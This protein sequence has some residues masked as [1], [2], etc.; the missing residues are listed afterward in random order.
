MDHV[1]VIANSLAAFPWEKV[2]DWV[3]ALALPAAG[4]Y[5]AYKF[6]NIQAAIGRQQAETARLAM[7]VSRNKL[8]LDLFDRRVKVYD[9]AF[10]MLGSFGMLGKID[11]EDEH[12]YW[13]GILSAKWLF[14]TE[15][16]TYLEQTLWQGMVAFRE[17]QQ[18]LDDS[19]PNE[20]RAAIAKEAAKRR[21][22]LM[23]QNSVLSEMFKPYLH[24][25][26]EL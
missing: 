13:S 23:D 22:W 12:R 1:A 18:A 16:V 6:G 15:V 14:D 20:G 21:R 9:T 5:V 17:A 3:K 10:S 25:D 7:R 24:F 19:D 11:N 2:M 8:K 4:V 26:R